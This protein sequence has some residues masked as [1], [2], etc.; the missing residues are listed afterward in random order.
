[1][2]PTLTTPNELTNFLET[3]KSL[4]P[5][6]YAANAGATRAHFETLLAPHFWEIAASGK[7]YSRDY[8]L[9]ELEKRQQNPFEQEW[10]TSDHYM[11][12][13]ADDLYLFHY[14]LHQP[15]RKSQRV[16]FW[17]RINN[18]WQLDFHQGTV[19]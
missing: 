7:R 11:Q 14:I 3:L 12:L 2:H 10:H 4:E 9:D 1:M 6:V 8:V 16:S 13:M 15:T 18:T 19:I 5:L 17:R